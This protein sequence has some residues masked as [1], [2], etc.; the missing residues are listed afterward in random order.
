MVATLVLLS[1]LQVDA[2][3][4]EART[5]RL[6]A[7]GDVMLG[8]ADPA[9]YLPPDDG[10]HSLDDVADWLRDADLT[11]ANLEGPLCDSGASSKCRGKAP[12][13]CYA[14]RTPTHYA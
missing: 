9:G 1:L 11:I 14:F 5:V 4:G 3:S 2:G 13:R 7:V 12:G 10:A 8:T 6:R